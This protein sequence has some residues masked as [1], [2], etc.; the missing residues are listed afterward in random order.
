VDV[1]IPGDV[2][3][4]RKKG[5]RKRGTRGLEAAVA[6]SHEEHEIKKGSKPMGVVGDGFRRL[7]I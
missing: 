5:K 3:K 4:R 1:D 7:Q 2:L 6:T